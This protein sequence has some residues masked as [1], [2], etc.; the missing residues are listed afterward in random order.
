M[1]VTYNTENL[2]AGRIETDQVP[3]DAG[4]Y[5]RGQALAFNTVTNQYCDFA[6]GNTTL[7]GIY[8]GEQETLE[9][10]DIRTAIRGGQ[11]LERGIVDATGQPH[12]IT[13]LI[14]SAAALLGFYIKR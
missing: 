8:L 10:G 5:Y 2:I 1:A 4:T 9:D 7:T 13:E 11:V 12:V 6:A 3:F 14:R